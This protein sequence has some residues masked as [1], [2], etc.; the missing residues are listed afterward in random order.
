MIQRGSQLWAKGVHPVEHRAGGDIDMTLGSQ[1]HDLSRREWQAAVPTHGHQDHVRGPA[2]PRK[3]EVEW[4]VKSRRQGWQ[5]YRWRPAASLAIAFRPW[6]RQDGQV[7]MK[8]KSTE[9]LV[10]SQT[11]PEPCV[12]LAK[13][14]RRR[15]NS[16]RPP[17]AADSPI[18]LCFSRVT[19][20]AGSSGREGVQR[21]KGNG[22]FFSFP[23]T[24]PRK[25]FTPP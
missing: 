9:H 14:E 6:V 25:N 24:I 3:R 22:S 11:P 10:S 5:W 23:L 19:H 13:Q 15:T 7:L 21:N 4:A 8:A 1:P 12:A 17:R 20:G 16:A 18:T 2:I